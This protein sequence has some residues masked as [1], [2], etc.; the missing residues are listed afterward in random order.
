MK[1]GTK[2]NHLFV[3]IQRVNFRN[4]GK[5][6]T[7]QRLHPENEIRQKTKELL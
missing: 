6:G 2:S 3:E 1:R 7:S 4:A 5:N